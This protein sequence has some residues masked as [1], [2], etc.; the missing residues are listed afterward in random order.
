MRFAEFDQYSEDL[1]LA[2]Y[3]VSEII[4][5]QLMKGEVREDFLKA[6]LESCNMPSLSLLKGT[7]SD[8]VAD[9]G[10][11]D[12]ILCRPNSHPRRIGGQWLVEKDDALC[13]IEVKGNCTGR[14]LARANLKAQQISEI[15]GNTAPVYGVMA[16]RTQLTEKTILNRF[17]WQYDQESHTYFDN[18]TMPNESPENWQTINY[19]N[20][21]FFL[22]L[23]EDKKL[24]LR[25]AELQPGIFRFIRNVSPPIIRDAFLMLRSLWISACTPPAA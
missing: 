23:E 18:A 20:L 6:T 2:H 14:D 25:K 12:L 7:L 15:D 17:G 19:P 24:F 1:L 8:G 13:V 22:S 11:L 21:D 10:Q 16:Y 9:A 5:N 4:S 3:S